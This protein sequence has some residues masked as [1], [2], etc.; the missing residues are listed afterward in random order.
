MLL[1][2]NRTHCCSCSMPNGKTVRGNTSSLR[3]LSSLPLNRLFVFAFISGLKMTRYYYRLEWLSLYSTS[4]P[5]VFHKRI[6]HQNFALYIISSYSIKRKICKQTKINNSQQKML[7][8]LNTTA[9]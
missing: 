9:N 1:Y 3:N 6:M 8:S 7:S 4:C 5:I 2:H